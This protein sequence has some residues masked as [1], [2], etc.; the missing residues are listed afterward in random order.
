[1]ADEFDDEIDGLPEQDDADD[2]AL[3]ELDRD[4]ELS[5]RAGV[6]KQLLETFEIVEKAFEDQHDRSNN[7]M[8][9]WD[10]YNCVLGSK[11]FYSGNS[12]IF[13]PIVYNAVT[14][15]VTR[16]VN[17]IFPNGG[18][19]VEAT[20]ADGSIPHGTIGL[21]EHYIRKA[22][23]RTEVMPALMRNGDV[24]GQYN[25]YVSWEKQKRHVVQRSKKPVEV[26][27]EGMQVQAPDQTVDSVDEITVEVGAPMVEVLAD[28]DIVVVPAT[29]D[30]LEQAIAVGG[31]VTIMRR[32][33]KSRIRQ[34]IREKQITKAAG[35]KLVLELQQEL[36]ESPRA[37]KAKRM[38]DAAG[39]R[40]GRGAFAQVYETWTVLKVGKEHR[41]C[42]AYYGG[43]DNILG[44]KRNPNWA[45]KLPLL[46][47]P[48]KKV[49][50]SFKG[51]SQI[52][53]V[54]DL[55]YFANDTANEG[56]DS[57]AYALMPII[58]TD[59][60]ANP[61][62]GSM[63]LSMAAIWETSPKDTQFA[64]FPELWKQAL[65]L[66]ASTKAE[67]MQTLGVNP[68]MITQSGGAKK[69]NQA[70]IAAEQQVDLLTT[71]DAVTVVEEGILTPL[72]NRFVEMDH[73]YREEDLVVPMYGEMGER[74]RMENV[75]PLA[76]E[77]RYQYRWFGVEAARGAQQIQQQ[78]AGMNVLRGIP[79]QQLN[80]WKLNIVPIISQL[81]ENVFGPRLAPLIFES[82]AQQMPVPIDME[83]QLLMTGYDVPTHEMDDDMAHIQGHQMLLQAGQNA[84][85][86]KI[87]AHVF[88]HMQQAMRKQMAMQQPPG[89]G[90]PGIPG[91]MPGQPPQAGPG[92]AGTPRIGAQPGV[93][94]TQGPPGMIHQD[95][96][97]D[98]AAMPRKM[99]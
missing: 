10:I 71:A 69:N 44:C 75:E 50:G 86:R 16:F 60:A 81:V 68:A 99:G 54:A 85:A 62:V 22:K 70:S 74:A 11:Q 76:F 67:I 64:Q 72:L 13:V 88:A 4:E 34:M 23:L 63:I 5:G 19:N 26:E 24:E 42:R 93:P 2:P 92:V 21:L 94:R 58:M 38:T 98:P 78:I 61:R 20:G 14:A 45:D 57:A 36:G 96:M 46:S 82:P 27:I 56:A 18:R 33:T 65:E 83:N 47:C 48:V 95:R 49:Q 9:Y 1:M 90:M 66:V 15:R 89:G 39:V 84:Q 17:Q 55:Q 3:A 8:D 87:Q 97:S 28:T 6:R 40:N 37:D 79:P 59:P 91:G 77:T 52:E 29:V 30:S 32:W 12:K 31:S 25:V 80:G 51:R 7:L 43:S 73:Q 53:P 35:E 41:L